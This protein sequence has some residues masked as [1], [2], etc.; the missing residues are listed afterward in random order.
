MILCEQIRDGNETNVRWNN[1]L[2]IN[3]VFD[4]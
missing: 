1:I 4:D 3:G 2:Q